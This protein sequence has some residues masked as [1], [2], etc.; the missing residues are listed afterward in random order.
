MG[1]RARA[2][3]WAQWRTLRNRLPHSNWIGLLFTAALTAVWYGGFTVLGIAAAFVM[4]SPARPDVIANVLPRGL[5]FCFLYWQVMPLIMASMGSALDIKKLVAYPIPHRELFALEVLLRIST[6]LEVLIV[7]F[8]T[9]VGLFLNP[10]IPVWAPLGLLP[11]IAFN[12]FLNAGIRDLMTRLL[13]RKRFREIAAFVFVLATALPQ[14][15]LFRGHGNVIARLF[16]PSS[17]S[18]LPWIATARWLDGDLSFATASILLAWTAAAYAFGRWQFERSLR[19][20]ADEQSPVD[21][22]RARFTGLVERFY[23]LPGLLFADPVAAIM[24]KELRSLTRSARFRLVFLMGFSFG[25]LIWVPMA[26]GGAGDSDSFMRQNYLA[27]VSIYA[28]LLLSDVLF[29]NTLGFDRSAAQVYFMVPVRLSRILAAKNLAAMLFVL[30][31][32]SAIASVCAIIRLPVAP[33]KL[34][35]AYMI[36][37]IVS[38]FLMSIGNLT[39][40]YNPRSINPARSFRS[41]AGGRT[42]ATLVLLFPIA[43]TP[44]ALAYLARYAFDSTLAFY[45]MLLF[46]GVLGGLVYAISM[47]SA[48]GAADRRK[49]EMIAALSRSESP[50]ES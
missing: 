31:E 43:I 17:G 32:V 9:A 25:L 4:A 39:S 26:F 12:L 50:V 45:G 35:E 18:F 1:S 10:K 22:P 24:E 46:A 41:S 16:T 48:V 21:M 13:A 2:I 15:L 47:E 33:G 49:E 30:L 38:M 6:G 42:Q 27:F 23:R 20:D 37:I 28:L 11:F 36:T 34:L 8:G 44:V 19:F 3:L 7:L 40:V 14:V 5:L 29:W